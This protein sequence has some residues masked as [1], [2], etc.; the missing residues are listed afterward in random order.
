MTNDVLMKNIV[1]LFIFTIQTTTL[2]YYTSSAFG[3][4]LYLALYVFGIILIKN[5]R[6]RNKKDLTLIS[7]TLFIATSFILPLSHI[8]SL[9]FALFNLFFII[10]FL[11]AK[12]VKYNL[13]SGEILNQ[14]LR[15]K[16]DLMILFSEKKKLFTIG[17]IIAGLLICFS[18]IFSYGLYMRFVEDGYISFGLQQFFA[19]LTP[20]WDSPYSARSIL[21]TIIF[22]FLIVIFVLSIYKYLSSNKRSGFIW[23]VPIVLSNFVTILI[24]SYGNVFSEI[25]TRIFIFTLIPISIFI[26]HEIKDKQLLSLLFISL[27]FITPSIYYGLDDGAITVSMVLQME[28]FCNNFLKNDSVDSLFIVALRDS[29]IRLYTGTKI[30]MIDIPASEN[31]SLLDLEQT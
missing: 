17:I 26:F 29:V 9:M 11:I 31:Y 7:G 25:R 21:Q 12:L 16:Q 8:G 14:I 27:I 15:R 28:T 5:V 1:P 3:L 20:Y 19:R 4:F 24:T 30:T 6:N 13:K 23:T 10:T 18:A 22:I 2:W